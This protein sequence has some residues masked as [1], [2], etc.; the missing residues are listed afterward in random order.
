MRV[1]QL[2]GLLPSS[3]SPS[4]QPF[5]GSQIDSLRNAGIEIEVLDL[6]ACCGKGW[7]KYIRGI[8]KIRKM[9]RLNQY[10]LIHAHYGYCGWVARFQRKVPV[11][12][13]LMGSDLLGIPDKSGRQTL[14]GRM[15]QWSSQILAQH[16]DHVIVKSNQMVGMLSR[17]AHMTVIP[18]G[19][20]FDLFKPMDQKDAREYFGLDVQQKV[21]L[22]ASDP[23]RAEKNYGLAQQ[24]FQNLMCRYSFTCNLWVFTGRPQKDLP[25]AMNAADALLLTSFSEGSPNVIKE[26]MACNLPIVSIPVGDVKEIISGARN[27]HVAEYDP[28]DIASKLASVLESGERSDGRQRIENLRLEVVAA[29]LVGVYGQV[30][31][32]ANSGRTFS[33]GKKLFND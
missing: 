9:V 32:K 26:A 10:D 25:M 31:E 7:K 15:S 21:V 6:A 16:V 33:N 17:K 8:F 19:V 22:F 24:A 13:S 11:V 12:V 1:L 3:R 2:V 4:A 28:S 5:V 30:L 23:Q 14:L 20:D 29:K 27:C 18:N